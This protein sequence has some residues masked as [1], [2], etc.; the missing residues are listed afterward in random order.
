MIDLDVIIKETHS[1][2][3]ERC[4][5]YD[6]ESKLLFTKT[7]NYTGIDFDVEELTRHIGYTHYAIHNHPVEDWSV[8]LQDLKFSLCYQIP[9]IIAITPKH[10]N[11]VKFKSNNISVNDL[12]CL[13]CEIWKRYYSHIG[14]SIDHDISHLLLTKLSE[15]WH[16]KVEYYHI[17]YK[18]ED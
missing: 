7:G 5:L 3:V 2:L 8:S 10:V 1:L 11:I 13:W 6:K 4:F 17:P 12:E 15:I 16:D 9:Y 18:Y 14:H